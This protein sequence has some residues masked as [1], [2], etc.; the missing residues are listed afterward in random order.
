M[1]DP[2]ANR[3]SLTRSIKAVKQKLN[4][5]FRDHGLFIFNVKPPAVRAH[6]RAS[7]ATLFIRPC[8]NEMCRK[9][10]GGGAGQRGSSKSK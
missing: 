2:R 7:T 9:R 5:S 8:L 10:G 3:S 4:E 1:Q 6:R